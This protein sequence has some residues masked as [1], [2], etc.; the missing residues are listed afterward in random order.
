MQLVATKFQLNSPISWGIF[1][2]LYC[3]SSTL[4]DAKC[5]MVPQT[6]KIPPP[7]K[8]REKK[9]CNFI[10]QGI[11]LTPVCFL[12]PKC[13]QE[14]KVMLIPDK[15][16]VS[17]PCGNDL[18]NLWALKPVFGSNREVGGMYFLCCPVETFY[19]W[20]F[21]HGIHGGWVQERGFS[22]KTYNHY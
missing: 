14:R 9:L 20:Y 22:L 17:H 18:H 11:A 15:V 8:K 2:G 10:V 7:K 13:P 5:Q 19:N 3:M 16:N 12:I 21:I 4:I 6:K 1:F